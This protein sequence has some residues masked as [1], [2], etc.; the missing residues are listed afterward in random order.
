MS[1]RP[2]PE[3]AGQPACLMR[4]RFM[5]DLTGVSGLAE[6]IA[7]KGAQGA[8]G[9]VEGGGGELAVALEVEQEVEGFA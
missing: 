9:L 2:E 5:P 6:I 4:F 8:G 1:D 7:V 3:S